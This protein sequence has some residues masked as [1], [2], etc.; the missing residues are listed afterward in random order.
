[1]RSRSPCAALK[2]SSFRI[3]SG[4]APILNEKQEP[5]RGIEAVLIPDRQRDR[6]D[7]YKTATSD[8]M[9]QFAIR[10]IPPGAYKIFAWDAIEEFGYYDPDLVRLSEQKGAPVR[11]LESS[12]ESLEVKIIPATGR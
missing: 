5:M 6:T 9:G 10:G 7:L 2:P 11:I 12:Q 3:A 8:Q 4:T 1:M